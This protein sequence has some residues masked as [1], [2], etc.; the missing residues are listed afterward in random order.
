MGGRGE[1]Q[2]VVKI[3]IE[4]LVQG[5]GFRP[6]IYL[7]A[8]QMRLTGEVSNTVNGVVIRAALSEKEEEL[9]LR[10]IRQECPPVAVIYRIEVVEREAGKG[11]FPDFRIVASGAEEA[12]ITRV[13]PDIAICDACLEDRKKQPHR[14][15]YPFINCTH[16]GPRFSIIKSL[17]Y[18]RARTTMDAFEMCDCCRKEYTNP[19]DRRFHAQP[20]A[21]N[22]CGPVYYATYQG[23]YTENYEELLRLSISLIEQGEVIAVKGVGGY[24]LVCDACNSHAVGKL[25]ELK[26]RDLKPFAV[27]FGQLQTLKTFV[28]CGA[29]EE[30]MLTSYRRPIVL[31]KQ[32]RQL[33]EGINPG[34]NTLGVMLPYMAIHYDWFEL[35]DTPALVMTSG[36]L[37]ECP[38]VITPEEAEVQFGGKVALLLHHNRPIQNRVD[39]SIE[40]LVASEP[41]LIRRSRGYTP[42][43]FFAEEN[44]EG[45]LAFG[46]EKTGSF[47]LGKDNTCILSQ[48]I[49]DLKNWETFTF[50]K[51]AMDRF[52]TLF[53]FS[54][55]ALVCDLHPDYF[56]SIYAETISREENLPLIRVQHHHAH[57]VA[58]MLEHKL[59]EK[60]IAIVWD[61]VGLGDDGQAWGGEFLLCDRTNYTRLAHLAY[62]PMP[63]GD[64]ASEEPWRMA[65]AY[66]HQFGL[67]L[68]RAFI[69]RIGAKKIGQIEMLM[70]KKL[71]CPLTSG[72]GRLFDALASLLGLCDV[73][74]HQAQAAICLE[75]TAAL[76]V[77]TEVYPVACS[78]SI[79][80]REMFEQIM[81]DINEHKPVSEICAK[82][83]ST[84]ADLIFRMSVKLLK[85]SGVSRVVLSGGCFQNKRLTELVVNLFSREGISLYIPC[86][87]P[88]NDGGIAAGQLAIAAAK[89]KR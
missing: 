34:M 39:D 78:E 9:F 53:R 43:P 57:A 65:V 67:S 6:F 33:A 74:N 16:C 10:R 86:R 22:H 79:S 38:I 82:I 17:P 1:E 30:E 62:I 45:I 84:L 49:G 83:H 28:H 48:Y 72:A 60:V 52:Q 56:S 59:N 51:E 75:Q 42:E 89:M 8:R 44:L 5:V 54:P 73:A 46:A 3:V 55:R 26:C 21:C 24:H 32:K 40:Q 80:F 58:C 29:K 35:L 41:C 69:A 15:N 37:S 23:R 13:A 11:C 70:D 36:N 81:V 27:M 71:N 19:A 50:Y 61:G 68:P 87:I 31:L 66:M 18:D 88:C 47:A 14:I 25:R 77:T 85:E 64:R 2:M 20:V 7:L 76:S 63:G 12:H 4:G